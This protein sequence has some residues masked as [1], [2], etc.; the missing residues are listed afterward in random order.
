M[1]GKLVK[2]GSEGLTAE[3]HSEG[4]S[5]LLGDASEV[6]EQDIVDLTLDE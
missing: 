5:A 2:T 3:G 6:A 4:E 1:G